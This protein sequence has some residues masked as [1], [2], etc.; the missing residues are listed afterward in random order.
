MISEVRPA[1]ASPEIAAIYADIRAVSG[2]PVVNLIWRHFAS[3]PGVLEWAWEAVR[4]LIGSEEIA[5][6]RQRLEA[7]VEIPAVTA[8]T[9]ANW[10]EAGV[11]AAELADIR[12]VVTGYIRG[13]L[14]NLIALTA[15]RLRLDRPDASPASFSPAP[16]Q[17]RAPPLP[18]LLRADALPAGVARDVRALAAKHDGTSDGTIPSLYLAL[19]VWPGVLRV[20]PV[21]LEALYAPDTLR[22]ARSSA[23]RAAEAEAS[24]LLPAIGPAPPGLPVMRPTLDR[25][26]RLVIPDMVPVCLALKDLLPPL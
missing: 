15:L 6:A 2:V 5:A 20:L 4:P 23:V 26:T 1:D 18:P 9:G 21:W 22:E 24:A 7:A 12:A 19:A 8:R 10:E 16:E 17:S 11:P 13:N 3:L 25:F 14:T